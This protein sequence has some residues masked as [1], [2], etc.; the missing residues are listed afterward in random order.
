MV[1]GPSTIFTQMGW[2]ALRSNHIGKRQYPRPYP[3]PTTVYTTVPT[4]VPPHDDSTYDQRLRQGQ[5]GKDK[6]GETMSMT[7]RTTVY[8]Y[9]RR[10]YIYI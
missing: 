5:V 7:V 9:I 3:V 8:I 10:K 2:F 1:E 6:G 4:M